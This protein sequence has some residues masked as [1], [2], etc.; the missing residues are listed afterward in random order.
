M[1]IGCQQ[2]QDLDDMCVKTSTE[3]RLYREEMLESVRL[4]FDTLKDV[5]FQVR[6]VEEQQDL[7]Q[8]L[9]QA[10]GATRTWSD[11]ARTVAEAAGVAAGSHVDGRLPH[12]TMGEEGSDLGRMKQIQ[13]TGASKAGSSRASVA[14]S[15]STPRS[16]QEPKVCIS[17]ASGSV[18]KDVRD[19]G[20]NFYV[21]LQL[22]Q[23]LFVNHERESE[24]ELNQAHNPR[25][26]HHI[27]Q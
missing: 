7:K 15:C 25:A 16:F 8:L 18:A 1:G 11:D 13:G 17:R 5:S 3:V 27:H 21:L 10:G 6:T 12:G 20:V 19:G 22:L 23:A 2:P 9:Q 24:A 14:R 4:A 26:I